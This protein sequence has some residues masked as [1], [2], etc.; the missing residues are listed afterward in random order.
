MRLI[1]ETIRDSEKKHTHL[2]EYSDEELFEELKDIENL[3]TGYLTGICA[4][5]LRRMLASE[6]KIK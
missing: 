5:I 6:G 2:K 3:E 4:E 1:G